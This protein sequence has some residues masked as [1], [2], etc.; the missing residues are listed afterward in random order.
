[1][2][3]KTIFYIIIIALI[4]SFIEIEA[5]TFFNN[6]QPK[7]TLSVKEQKMH[8]LELGSNLRYQQCLK[9]IQ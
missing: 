9:L 1:M 3:R 7:P 2:N 6:S 4:A 5:I 8:C